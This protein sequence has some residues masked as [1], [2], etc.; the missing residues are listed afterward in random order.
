[1]NALGRGSK[2]IAARW[3]PSK[4]KNTQVPVASISHV[5]QIPSRIKT[6]ASALTNLLIRGEVVPCMGMWS[7]N[8][9]LADCLTSLMPT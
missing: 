3:H 5:C 6:R 2:N 7:D 1:L 4:K 8:D 9:K